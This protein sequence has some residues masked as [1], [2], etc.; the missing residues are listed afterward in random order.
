M[1]FYVKDGILNF[2]GSQ[3]NTGNIQVIW[4]NE[5]ESARTKF[6][7]VT[8]FGLLYENYWNIIANLKNEQGAAYTDY[9]SIKSEFAEFAWNNNTITITNTSIKAVPS[10]AGG[11]I[12]PVSTSIKQSDG[13]QKT[14]VV[15]ATGDAISP[16]ATY[17]RSSVEIT[18]P[19]TTPTYSAGDSI[20]ETSPVIKELTNV[21]TSAGGGG[22]IM[23]CVIK[24]DDVTNMSGKS[25]MLYLYNVAPTPI[26]DDSAFTEL[27]ADKGKD[28]IAIPVTF[29]T[30]TTGSTSCTAEVS[31]IKSFVCATGST[32][33]YCAL[34]YTTGG[35]VAASKHFNIVLRT[36]IS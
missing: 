15:N 27:Y 2:G 6:K 30:P 17:L 23:D 19:N 3:Y 26:A 24:C 33:L 35:L 25:V 13:S 7:L 5:V 28:P 1:K 29:N 12:I 4:D 31:V 9:N 22:V 34:Q 32:S 10:D 36:I 21:T 18:R 14:Q 11:T 8:P 16:N 20:N